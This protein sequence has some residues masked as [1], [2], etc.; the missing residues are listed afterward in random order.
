MEANTWAYRACNHSCNAPD[1]NGHY[2]WCDSNGTCA[3]DIITDDHPETA[4]GPGSE[5]TINTSEE[6][7]I[8]VDFDKNTLG[9]FS[10]YTI[11][12]TQEGREV[13]MIQNDCE[14]ELKKNT[15][16]LENGMVFAMSVWESWDFDWLQ[17]GRCSG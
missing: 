12:F 7:H 13:K 4:Y 1:S 11:T 5:Y 15:E 8:R 3:V 9:E 14:N 17:H 6:F 16:D 10:A 2:N